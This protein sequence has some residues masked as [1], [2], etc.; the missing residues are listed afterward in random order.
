MLHWG[1]FGQGSF[2][3]LGI[4]KNQELDHVKYPL[5]LYWMGL[6]VR[7]LC[8]R[9]YVPGALYLV[10]GWSIESRMCLLHL[11]VQGASVLHIGQASCALLG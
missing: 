6:I 11:G 2:G 1:A 3:G 5:V 4:A 10:D 7:C 8:H 9:S